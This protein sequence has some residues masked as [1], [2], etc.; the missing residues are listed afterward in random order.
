[1]GKLVALVDGSIYSES[2]C[3]HAAWVAKG[4]G[5]SVEIVHVLGLRDDSGEPQNLIGHIILAVL[6]SML[7]ELAE[8]DAHAA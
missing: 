4:K 6:S 1:M 3:D 5:F 2:V 8:F 7:A